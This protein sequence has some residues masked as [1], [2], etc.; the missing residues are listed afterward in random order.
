[1][2]RKASDAKRQ[3]ALLFG[4]FNPIH[5]GHCAIVRFLL[6]QTEADEVRL[7]VT[8][9]NPLGKKDLA[10]AHLRLETAREAIARLGLK[11]T[12]SDIEFHL[13]EP[14]YTL[15]T[16]EYLDRSEPESEHILV[17][18]A[19]NLERL[20]RWYGFETLVERYQIWVYPRTGTDLEAL[21]ARYNAGGAARRIR[22]LSGARFDISSTEIREG[23]KAGK[24]MSRWRP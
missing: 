4:S 9:R 11:A 16:L 7:V 23:E 15:R 22:A 20:E 5:T 10:D 6:E 3:V 2:K 17:I 14:S 19:D 1:M 24:D 12:V 18:G 8:P 13:P 21:C